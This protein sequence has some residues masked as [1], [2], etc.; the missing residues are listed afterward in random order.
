MLN[1]EMTADEITGAVNALRE[2]IGAC[3]DASSVF[4][5]EEADRAY[6]DLSFHLAPNGSVIGVPTIKSIGEGP[7]RELGR[8]ASK[9]VMQCAPYNMLP[10]DKYQNWELVEARFT[11][12]GM[13]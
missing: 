11:V 2:R 13:E 8:I 12:G 9:A 7:S 10:A 4:S 5:L 6:A 3:F 1:E